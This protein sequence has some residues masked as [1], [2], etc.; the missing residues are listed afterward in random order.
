[1]NISH[2]FTY[3]GLEN[4]HIC[5]TAGSSVKNQKNPKSITVLVPKIV[6]VVISNKS[7]ELQN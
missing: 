2:I 7:I 6:R 5:K 4:M 3:H 1:M